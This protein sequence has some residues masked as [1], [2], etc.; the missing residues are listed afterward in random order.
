MLCIY[1]HFCFTFWFPSCLR[2]HEL[3]FCWLLFKIILLSGVMYFLCLSRNYKT[4]IS[5]GETHSTLQVCPGTYPTSADCKGHNYTQVTPESPRAGSKARSSFH[6]V[7]KEN[8]G[9][10]WLYTALWEGIS[11]V[12]SIVW[13]HHF[14]IILF[15]FFNTNYFVEVISGT[16]I[17]LQ[18]KTAKQLSRKQLPLRGISN[19]KIKT[20][21]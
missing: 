1:K 2:N 4:L 14:Y 20:H 8:V 18:S 16:R 3:R 9:E 21:Y 15:F 19:G 7:W 5:T 11:S 6:N 17:K 10:K 12:T 13:V